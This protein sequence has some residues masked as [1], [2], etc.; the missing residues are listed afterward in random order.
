MVSWKRPLYKETWPIDREAGQR[1][2]GWSGWPDGKKFAL[3]LTH[4]VETTK[5]HDNCRKLMAL[6][7]RLGMYSSFNFV[8]ERYTVSAELRRHITNN[9]FEVSVHGLYHDGKL[10]RSRAKFQRR[11]LKINKYLN[12]WGAV[13]F[14][15]PSMQ[16]NLEWTHDLNITYDSSTFDTDPFEPQNEN[17]GT[18]FPFYVPNSSGSS[19][20]VELPSTLPQDFTLFILMKEK[21]IS[22]WKEKL[23]WIVERGG[24]VLLIA[25][26]DYMNFEKRRCRNDEYPAELYI[27]FLNHIKDNYT[28]QYW[29]PLPMDLARFWKKGVK[30]KAEISTLNRPMEMPIT[31]KGGN[32]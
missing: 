6:E 12:E 26:P 29:N 32:L 4:D 16:N 19:G 28:N 5:G 11:A 30:N 24:M 9:G 18:I 27:E 14:S 10:Y 20:Y 21:G 23:E 7:K 1:P 22:V 17:V 8:P 25:H 3:I 13:G 15:S 31:N 2:D